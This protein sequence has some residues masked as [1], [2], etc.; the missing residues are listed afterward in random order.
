MLSRSK[1]SEKNDNRQQKGEYVSSVGGQQIVFNNVANLVEHKTEAAKRAEQAQIV[2]EAKAYSD[3]QIDYMTGFFEKYNVK[4]SVNYNFSV[5][6]A[7]LDFL[8]DLKDGGFRKSGE[9]PDIIHETNQVL[10]AMHALEHGLL[11]NKW[12]KIEKKH[13]ALSTWFG[14]KFGHDIMEDGDKFHKKKPHI[15][16]ETAIFKKDLIKKIIGKLEERQNRSVTMKEIELI[17]RTAHKIETLTRERKFTPDDFAKFVKHKIEALRQSNQIGFD[18]YARL[19]NQTLNLSNVS[20]GK[21]VKLDKAYTDLFKQLMNRRTGPFYNPY[22]YARV[23]DDKTEIIVTAYGATNFIGVDTNLYIRA[24]TR[25]DPYT[26]DTKFSDGIENVCSR[27]GVPESLAKRQKYLG[28]ATHIYN[29]IDGL[30]ELS[31]YKIKG[32]PLTPFFKSEKKMTGLLSSLNEWVIQHDQRSNPPGGRVKD[33]TSLLR[34]PGD[35]TTPL[36]LSP[37]LGKKKRGKYDALDAYDGVPDPSHP[38]IIFFEGFYKQIKESQDQNLYILCEAFLQ[39]IEEHGG[40]DITD[41]LR[42]HI[43]YVPAIITNDNNKLTLD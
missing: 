16:T 27:I 41:R 42:K 34:K 2:A 9:K 6:L 13:G 30:S 40:K 12:Q 14:R 25:K 22:V 21:P 23:E 36:V 24:N 17:G 37:F 43:S 1:N 38:L 29:S 11:K 39:G 5:S 19:K 4:K 10:P 28:S 20:E 7:Y 33:A 8:K 18:L 26:A 31:N 3:Q 15:I 35:E 32:S